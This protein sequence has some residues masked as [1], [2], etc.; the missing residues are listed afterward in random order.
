MYQYSS[1]HSG[2]NSISYFI[3]SPLVRSCDGKGAKIGSRSKHS[4]QHGIWMTSKQSRIYNESCVLNYKC[5][6]VCAR[7]HFLYWYWDRRTWSTAA[8]GW[9]GRTTNPR[10]NCRWSRNLC[11][12]PILQNILGFRIF[13]VTNTLLCR[14]FSSQIFLGFRIFSIQ[15]VSP[16]RRFHRVLERFLFQSS[17]TVP[18]SK[19]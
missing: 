7:C 5:D 4:S 15:L 12:S 1:E 9:R 8:W 16:A 18:P 10:T 13:S 6:P 3:L 11:H 14:I 17:R 2:R 19:F